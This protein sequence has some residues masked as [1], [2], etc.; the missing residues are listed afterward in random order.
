[1]TSLGRDHDHHSVLM[2]LRARG[3]S[4][5]IDSVCRQRGVLPEELLGRS[6][7]RSVARA[8]QELWWKIKNLSE[9]EYSCCEIARIFQRDH[10]T[11][12]SGVL[13]HEQR[14]R[15]TTGGT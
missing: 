11:V 14:R 10:T 13:A 6:R 12:S 1:M 8:R 9:R 5:L 2:A 15:L 3:L 7:A 4:D